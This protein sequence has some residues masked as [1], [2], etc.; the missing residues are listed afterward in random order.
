MLHTRVIALALFG[1]LC[2]TMAGAAGSFPDA[3][4]MDSRGD[5]GQGPASEL[6]QH[7]DGTVQDKVGMGGLPDIVVRCGADGSEENSLDTGSTKSKFASNPAFGIVVTVLFSGSMLY[8]LVA[9]MYLNYI[10]CCKRGP[11]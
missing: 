10:A 5:V 3:V 1:A 9:F 4:V 2:L 6:V 8:A 7:L 11:A